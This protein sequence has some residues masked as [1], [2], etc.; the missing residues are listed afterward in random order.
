MDGVDKGLA[1]DM[2]KKYEMCYAYNSFNF[3]YKQSMPRCECEEFVAHHNMCKGG[4]WEVRT[5]KEY[6]V[7]FESLKHVFYAGDGSMLDK[8]GLN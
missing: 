6:Q 3:Y 1:E 7:H 2:L 5:K 8:Y 4:H